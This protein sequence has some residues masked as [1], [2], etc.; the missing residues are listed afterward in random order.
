VTTID[1]YGQRRAREAMQDTW[2]HLGAHPGPRYSGNIRFA[3]GCYGDRV[4]LAVDFG[5][6]SDG[7]WFYEGIHEWLID[8]D[9]EPGAIY[10]FEGTYRLAKGGRHVFEGTISREDE[11]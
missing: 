9:T 2:G 1:A 7:P 11:G 4:V 3:E 6:A 5:K 10:R 8:R